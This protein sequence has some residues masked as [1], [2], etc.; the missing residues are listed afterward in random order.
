MVEKIDEIGR[1]ERSKKQKK[2]GIKS[3]KGKDEIGNIR[4]TRGI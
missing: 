3:W 2:N 4:R 1:V